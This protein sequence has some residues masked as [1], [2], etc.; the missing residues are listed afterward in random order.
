MRAQVDGAAEAA[1]VGPGLLPG[2][3]HF[4]G[5]RHLLPLVLRRRASWTRSTPGA[6]LA[7]PQPPCANRSHPA[8]PTRRFGT[9]P[10]PCI[11]LA[12]LACL[13][14]I[15]P[16][17][18]VVFAGAQFSPSTSARVEGGV[19]MRRGGGAAAH[20][21][22][23]DGALDARAEGHRKCTVQIQGGGP[24]GRALKFSKPVII[25]VGILLL[26]IFIRI[27]HGDFPRGSWIPMV[28]GTCTEHAQKTFCQQ[29]RHIFRL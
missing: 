28:A 16:P 24:P 4:R 7:R 5:R 12:P 25:S 17:F 6:P 22:R 10:P 3:R 13:A 1:G 9:F 26:K 18:A 2:A 11:P 23:G 20:M 19:P 27:P 8:H 21:G 29:R 15:L 14:A